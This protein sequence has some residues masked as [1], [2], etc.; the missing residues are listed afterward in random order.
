MSSNTPTYVAGLLLGVLPIGSWE[1]F[2]TLSI[3]SK[4][5]IDLCFPGI[6][7]VPYTLLLKAFSRIWLTSVLLPEPDTPVTSVNVPSGNLTF[8]FLRLFSL[9]PL[10]SINL[11]FLFFFFLVL[12]FLTF[13][14]GIYR[15]NY[16]DF[17]WLRLEFH[18]P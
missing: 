14:L 11:P 5:F 2:T 6:T 17:S 3:S 7:I 13:Q 12:Q 10:I 9:A 16:L 18:K 8:M 1:I 15:L 4:P